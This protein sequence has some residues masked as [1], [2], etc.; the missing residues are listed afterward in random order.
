[1][2]VVTPP[3][4]NFTTAY[5]PIVWQVMFTTNPQD[6]ITN[7]KFTILVGATVIAVGRVAPYQAVP[8]LTPP[9]IEY[10]F[11]V[12]VQQYIQRYL[13]TEVRRSVFGNLNDETRVKNTD[14]YVE[15]TVQFQYEYRSSSTGKIQTYPAIDYSGFQRA[16]ITTRQNGDDQSLNDFL[17]LPFIT[18]EKQFLTNSPT[19]RTISPTENVFLSYLG[20]WN[21]ILIETYTAAGAFINRAYLPT[22]GGSTDNEMNTTGVGKPQL[23][24]IPTAQYWQA[25]RPNFTNAAYYTINAGLGLNMGSFIIFVNNSTQ[26]VYTFGDECS[27]NLRLYWIN[28]LGG[29]DHFDFPYQE[30]GINVT[31]DLFQKPLVTPHTV[32]DYGRARTNIKANRAYQVSKLMTNSEMAWVKDLFYSVEVYL[33][34]PANSSEYLRCWI[35]DTEVAERRKVGLFDVSFTLN[36]SQDVVTHRI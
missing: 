2:A 19:S 29:V 27:K 34:N 26:H 10:Y 3:T 11:Y 25:L 21:Y 4:Y 13:T 6:P 5:R 8:S 20:K 24:A 16:C 17:G 12:D 32:D 1:M 14:S 9:F 36:L 22:F 30:L 31:S 28:S 7:C 23:D 15:F 33:V 35:S 18:A